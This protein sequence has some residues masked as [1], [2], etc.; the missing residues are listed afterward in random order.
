MQQNNGHAKLAP[1]ASERWFACPGSIRLEAQVP[2]PPD[3]E[4]A[5]EGTAAHALASMCLE[6]WTDAAEYDT[7]TV[8]HKS[9]ERVWEVT[10]D[11]AQAVQVY[12]DKVRSVCSK[13]DVESGKKIMYVEVRFDLSW[14]LD[15]V[16]GTSDCVILDIEAK[17]LYV[18]DYKH[19]QGVDVDVDGNTQLLIYAVGA[20]YEIAAQRKAQ[21]IHDVIEDVKLVIVQPR[22]YSTERH[23][24]ES[25]DGLTAS[26]ILI[27]EKEVLR[28]SVKNTMHVDAPLHVGDHCQF[29]PAIAV[30]PQQLKHAM[31]VARQDFDTE[32]VLLPPPDQLTPDDLVRVKKSALLFKHWASSVEAYMQQQA[33]LGT[34]YPG[35]KLVRKKSNREWI[36]EEVAET[37]IESMLG[38][39]A[40]E[41]KFLSVAK[42]EK[43]LTK[44]KIKPAER[45]NI[46]GPLLH[47]PEKGLTLVED[48]DN[49][50][51]VAAP[52]I[53]D[54]LDSADFMQ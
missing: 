13:E 23:I 47:R 8:Q 50:H 5:A 31:A 29:C 53:M 51:A 32:P 37:M 24:K 7:I 18:F 30:C 19:G 6:N 21:S 14:L 33:E 49:R 54:F 38:D 40:Y 44:M 26:K 16:Y 27:W 34:I 28:E 4:Y 35:Y 20:I 15:E 25:K 1:S 42:V 11:M 12:L 17:K 52:A 2:E 39:A 3:S 10:E 41:K 45:E 43:V 22:I 9:G 36:D 48:T 46:I